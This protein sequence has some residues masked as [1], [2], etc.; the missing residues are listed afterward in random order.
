MKKTGLRCR[1]VLPRILGAALLL[2]LTL[3]VILWFCGIYDISFLPRPDFDPDDGT[4]SDS[5]PE[6][7]EE[8]QQSSPYLAIG[9]G[10]DAFI[11]LEAA[12]PTADELAALP[13]SFALCTDA[14][15]LDAAA[16]YQSG[17]SRLVRLAI[18]AL[19]TTRCS[20]TKQVRVV[21]KTVL[22][23]QY[24]TEFTEEFQTQDRPSVEIA[25]GYLIVATGDSFSIL[26]RTGATLLQNY[27][28]LEYS[29]T[30]LDDGQG[31]ILFQS[32]DTYYA[33][34]DGAFVPAEVSEE[35]LKWSL[36]C[37]LP[38]GYGDDGISTVYCENGLYGYKTPGGDTKTE[39]KY[40]RAFPHHEG[41]AIAYERKNVVI[42]DENYEVTATIPY[43][44]DDVFLTLA[45]VTIP[46]TFGE[47]FYG[48]N[49][50]DHGL[51]V[52][53]TRRN[54]RTYRVFNYT[55]I[56]DEGRLY[57][58]NGEL[59]SL[60]QGY[61]LRGYAD[62]MLLLQKSGEERYG[63]MDFC[64]NWVVN[65]YFTGATPFYQG[66][67]I[68]EKDGKKGVI[69][70]NGNTV[71]PLCFSE[72]SAPSRGLIAAYNDTCGWLIFAIDK[73]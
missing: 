54:L 10:A 33:L 42:L 61:E 62:G 65:P 44:T 20:G 21:R 35:S 34:R 69:D 25:G 31:H 45:E 55:K 38:L 49:T 66:L 67:A 5:A 7:P 26:N 50:F 40:L 12:E 68:I 19:P 63:F 13:K 32:G 58:K 6:D 59:I 30:G 46:H 16:V 8:P 23:D 14:A 47:E 39:A 36:L 15:A 2:F 37:E 22:D 57:N 17:S 70:T 9:I 28:P 53:R 18:E 41:L 24:R 1:C 11:G 56:Y 71:L 73:T 64:G 43:E 48:L 52:F 29:P 51:T 4:V 3:A 27:S 60:P 72:V